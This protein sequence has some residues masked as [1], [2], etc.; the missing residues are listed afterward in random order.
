MVWHIGNGQILRVGNKSQEWSRALIDVVVGYDADIA[1]VRRVMAEVA[2]ALAADPE[3]SDDVLEAPDVW[4]IEDLSTE[5]VVVRMVVKTRPAAQFALLRAMRERLI[6]GLAAAG[7][8]FAAA[9]ATTEVV[10]RDARVE[11]T[12]R[13]PRRAPPNL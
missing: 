3:W 12:E 9:G 11:P 8:T 2:T 7:I 1:T 5:G 4:G 13:A 6:A 10:L